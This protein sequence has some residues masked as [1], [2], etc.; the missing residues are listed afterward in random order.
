MPDLYRHPIIESPGPAGAQLHPSGDDWIEIARVDGWVYGACESL[1]AVDGLLIEF[2]EQ[3]PDRLERIIAASPRHRFLLAALAS[4]RYDAEV[5]G[6]VWSGWPV[7]T[8]RASQAAIAH[9]RQ[10][11][12]CGLRRDGAVWKF[13]DVVSR[14]LTNAQVIDLAAAVFSYCQSCW[15]NESVIATQIRQ[16]LVPDETILHRGWPDIA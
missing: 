4:R 7:A 8:D 10:A 6:I 5:A 13:A 15:D 11:A 14:P 2:V 9:A 1:P 12:D 3:S 16:C